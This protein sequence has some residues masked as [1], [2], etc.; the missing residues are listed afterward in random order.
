VF[1]VFVDGVDGDFELELP[2]FEVGFSEADLE[3][4]FFFASYG[5]SLE[6]G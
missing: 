5:D 4:Q 6:F 1:A 3:E 2:S